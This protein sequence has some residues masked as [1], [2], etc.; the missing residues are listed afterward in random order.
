MAVQMNGQANAAPKTM[1]AKTAPAKEA[2]PNQ[3]QAPVMPGKADFLKEF[4]RLPESRFRTTE[5][6]L[7]VA[8][9]QEGFGQAA[10]TGMTVSVQYTGW[11]AEGVM[12]DSSVDKGKP[13]SFRLGQGTVIKGWEE[14]IAGMKPGEKRQLIIPASLAYGDREVGKI[15]PGATLVF[16]VE[17][18]SVDAGPGNPNG[19]VSK[20]A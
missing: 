9:I 2:A 7:Q 14:G 6:G 16:N 15:P 19:T 5:S 8:V 13:F 11:T 10:S 4:A 20:Y 12:F 18:V 1:P 17:A 3:K